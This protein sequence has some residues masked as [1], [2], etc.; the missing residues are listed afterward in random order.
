M[1]KTA[2][3]AL[4]VLALASCRGR[5][6]QAEFDN[7][8]N[9]I[10]DNFIEAMPQEPA[11]LPPVLNQSNATNVTEPVAPPPSVSETE[12]MQEDA[13]ATGMTAR[14]DRSDSVNETQPVAEQ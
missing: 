6:E 1:K 7:A 3:I 4:A 8:A 12:Q 9:V 13:D 5:D 14:V 10:D 11:P 2:L